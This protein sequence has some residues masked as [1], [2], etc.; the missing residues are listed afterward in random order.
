MKTALLLAGALAI[1]G[2]GVAI[3]EPSYS[4]TVTASGLN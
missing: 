3:D 4:M 2:A 1:L